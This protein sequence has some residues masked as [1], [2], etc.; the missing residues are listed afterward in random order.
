MGKIK[1]GKIR[2]SMSYENHGFPYLVQEK[3]LLY[4]ALLGFLRIL[5]LHVITSGDSE[6]P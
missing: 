3:L 4:R 5:P 6:R 2:I 1:P